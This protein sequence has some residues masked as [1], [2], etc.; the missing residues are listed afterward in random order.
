MILLG[1]DSF[2]SGLM[3]LS[4][5]TTRKK[6]VQVPPLEATSSQDELATPEAKTKD[7]GLVYS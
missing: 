6:E 3:G 7:L 5:S 4:K 2:P 1:I